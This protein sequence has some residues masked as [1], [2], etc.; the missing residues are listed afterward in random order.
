MIN[1]GPVPPACVAILNARPNVSVEAGR[2][3]T[4]AV[5]CWGELVLRFRCEGAGRACSLT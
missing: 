3:P 1:T 2:L 4:L 5:R